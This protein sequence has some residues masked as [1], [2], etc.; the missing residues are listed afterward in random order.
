MTGSI[1]QPLTPIPERRSNQAFTFIG[2]D[3]FSN[4]SGELRYDAGRVAGDV[5]GD[6]IADMEIEIANFAVLTV[7]DFIL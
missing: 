2:T 4:T 6:G 5:D 7:D 1:W 3:V